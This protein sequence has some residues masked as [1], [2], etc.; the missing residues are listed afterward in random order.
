MLFP[1][2][3]GEVFQQAVVLHDGP[4]AAFANVFTKPPVSTAQ[5]LHPDRYFAKTPSTTPDLPKPAAGMKAAVEGIFGE[6]DMHVLLRQYASSA[7]AEGLAPGMKG[8]HYRIDEERS[9]AKGEKE[10]RAALLFATEWTDEDS[11]VAFLNA[12]Q[13]V[14][15]K[16]WKHV[17]KGD[18]NATHISGR[19][20]DGYYRVERN[21]R[22]VLA[23][24][25]FAGK[26]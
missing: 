13:D 15:E 11:A 6:E 1:Y 21:G 26:Q 22:I 7:I 24:E 20:E 8:G 5:V 23:R 2:E 18:Q 3:E 10:P 25:G 19:S 17:E 14:V 16:K 4:Q 12:Y 9:A